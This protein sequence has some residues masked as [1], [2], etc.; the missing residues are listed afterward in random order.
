MKTNYMAHYYLPVTPTFVLLYKYK[1]FS[2][3]GKCRLCEAKKSLVYFL[4]IVNRAF[5]FTT[6]IAIY[7]ICW[8]KMLKFL[9]IFVIFFYESVHCAY[10]IHIGLTLAHAHD[11]CSLYEIAVL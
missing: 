2:K 5:C 7:Q 8:I 3:Y 4:N 1:N 9:F 10:A 11:D 6:A